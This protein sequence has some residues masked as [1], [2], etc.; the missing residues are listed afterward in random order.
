MIL[1]IALLH[2]TTSL[3]SLWTYTLFYALCS[4]SNDQDIERMQRFFFTDDEQGEP[5][6]ISS[7]TACLAIKQFL[8][9]QTAH[10]GQAPS[11][12]PT[13]SPEDDGDDHNHSQVSGEMCTL[14]KL[15][16]A[17]QHAEL[18]TSVQMSEELGC[19]PVY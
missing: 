8:K 12:F 16:C 13:Q 5:E 11:A 15:S 19:R 10:S 4:I 9:E 18:C 14:K 3:I 2:A 7:D 1:Q 6:L 17:L